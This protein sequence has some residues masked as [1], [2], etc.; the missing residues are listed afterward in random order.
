[1]SAR[2]G[3][4]S[5]I[6][7]KE[8]S[9]GP[10]GCADVETWSAV[11]RAVPP[12]ATLSVALGDL[13]DWND[14]PTPPQSAFEGI[15]FRKLG[16][17]GEA[18][19][20]WRQAWRQLRRHWGGE[21]AWVA[22]AYLDAEAA[23]APSCDEIRD[24]VASDPEIDGLLLDSWQKGGGSRAPTINADWLAPMR[25]SGRFVALAGGLDEASIGRLGPIVPDLIGVRGAACRGGDRLSE[26]DPSRV[27]S[28]R[29]AVDRLMLT[30]A[31]SGSLPTPAG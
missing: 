28:L 6:D 25:A 15:A 3:G 22:V 5:V 2:A 9:R 13:R 20:D 10:L 8:P 31:R 7:V 30:A 26:I 11:R 19:R 4:A 1:M 12:T 21:S 18:G 27:R 14:R 17:A 29:R 24:A 16:F 23:G